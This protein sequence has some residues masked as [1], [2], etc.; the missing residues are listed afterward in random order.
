MHKEREAFMMSCD[1]TLMYSQYIEE[2]LKPWF[3]EQ[4]KAGKIK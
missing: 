3:E 4:R 1:H 2:Y